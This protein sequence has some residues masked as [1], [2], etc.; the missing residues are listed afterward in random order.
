MEM[1][2]EK[3]FLLEWSIPKDYNK[4]TIS[5]LMEFQDTENYRVYSSYRK[6][7]STFK[8]IIKYKFVVDKKTT[9]TTLPITN[10]RQDNTRNSHLCT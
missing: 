7:L 4:K 3:N 1:M 8:Y 5:K 2:I 6:V 9:N 10:M